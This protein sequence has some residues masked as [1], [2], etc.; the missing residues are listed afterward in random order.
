MSQ[1]QRPFPDRDARGVAGQGYDGDIPDRE[2]PRDECGV[3]GLSTP[4]GDGVAQ[5]AF[6]GLFALAQR[7][8]RDNG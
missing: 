5:L 8:N 1:S 4:S 3:L 2:G 6:F 7:W